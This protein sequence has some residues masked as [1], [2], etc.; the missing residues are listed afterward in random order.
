[1]PVIPNLQLRCAGQYNWVPTGRSLKSDNCVNYVEGGR[2]G[3]NAT[4]LVVEETS[5]AF[6]EQ[7]RF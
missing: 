7:G 2:R 6:G 5:M 1:M 3:G 4:F